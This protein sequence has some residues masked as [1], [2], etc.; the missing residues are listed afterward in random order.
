[1]SS[2]VTSA[3][4]VLVAMIWANNIPFRLGSAESG[5]FAVSTVGAEEGGE[6][7]SVEVKMPRESSPHVLRR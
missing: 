7:T 3:L 4:A 6:E 5:A 2:S 1:M